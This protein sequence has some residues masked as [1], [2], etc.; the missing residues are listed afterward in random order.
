MTKAEWIEKQVE[1]KVTTMTLDAHNKTTLRS[2][3]SKEYDGLEREAVRE[4]SHN[5]PVEGYYE[6]NPTD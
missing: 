4:D 3:L 6:T 5:F 2:M 1:A